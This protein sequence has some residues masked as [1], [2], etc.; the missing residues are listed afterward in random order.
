MILA[1][2]TNKEGEPI[3][4][5]RTFTESQWEDI[6][7]LP[8]LRWM[9]LP[10]IENDYSYDNLKRMTKRQIVTTFGLNTEDMELTKKE[11][12]KKITE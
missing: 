4:G 6:Q 1:Y 8:N 5:E 11:I 12:I 2:P 10:E 7:K 3:G 9:Q